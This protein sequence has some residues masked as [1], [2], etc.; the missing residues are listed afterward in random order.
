MGSQLFYSTQQDWEKLPMLSKMKELKGPCT[1]YFILNITIMWPI[2][3]HRKNLK[4]SQ[5]ILLLLDAD[6]FDFVPETKTFKARDP[7]KFSTFLNEI[8]EDRVIVV[9]NKADKLK[10]I[11][12][13]DSCKILLGE[14]S[15]PINSVISCKTEQNTIDLINLLSKRVISQR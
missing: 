5:L 3:S 15:F 14:S 12:L 13:Q 1:I 4:E 7:S 9:L 2:S 8:A 6:D 10:E 11:N